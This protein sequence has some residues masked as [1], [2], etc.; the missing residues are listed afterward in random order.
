MKDKE[1]KDDTLLTIKDWINSFWA[2][3]EEDL[4]LFKSDLKEKL[5]DPKGLIMEI[6]DRIKTRKAYY[7]I[8]KYLSIRDVPKEELPWVE[9]K[10]E[11][12]LSREAF[13]SESL[14]KILEFFSSFL[15]E[16]D[17][18]QLKEKTIFLPEDKLIIH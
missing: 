7:K 15:S 17:F 14:E 11:E 5:Q 10:L 16:E 2:F 8:F 18:N 13:I 6:R 12:I 1:F 3:Q 9:K 4:K